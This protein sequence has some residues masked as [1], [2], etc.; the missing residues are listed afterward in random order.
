MKT[1]SLKVGTVFSKILN[2]KKVFGIVTGKN[3]EWGIISK[4]TAV[5]K[6][7]ENGLYIESL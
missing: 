7:L 4:E 2:G 6:A 3:G 1:S 5:L